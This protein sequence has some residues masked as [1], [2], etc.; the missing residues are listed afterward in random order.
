MGT[1]ISYW[2]R[3]N[4]T[5]DKREMLLE[6]ICKI[7]LTEQLHMDE[8]LFRSI[9]FSTMPRLMQE[10]YVCGNRQVREENSKLLLTLLETLTPQ[11][12]TWKIQEK[13]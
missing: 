13:E 11:H 4:G 8:K 3:L 2:L 1:E 12:E 5:F 7:F 10:R 6:A 9:Y